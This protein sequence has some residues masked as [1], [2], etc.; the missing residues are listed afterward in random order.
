MSGVKF[1]AVLEFIYLFYTNRIWIYCY[2][3][4]CIF[5]WNGNSMTRRNWKKAIILKSKGTIHL[6]IYIYII[7]FDELDKRRYTYNKVNKNIHSIHS[8]Y[9]YTY[10]T[11]K[12]YIITTHHTYTQKEE[13]YENI[14]I[15]Y[16]IYQNVFSRYYN[17]IKPLIISPPTTK[18]Q[19]G[20]TGKMT[21]LN[22]YIDSY[23]INY[24][25][26][27]RNH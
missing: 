18:I 12:Q 16:N 8:L 6:K 7:L 17:T 21:F 19:I 5:F 4:N 1:Q 23:Q 25:I 22:N 9:I 2:Q 14:F 27:L 15:I 26:S 24:I 10:I 13:T 11:N 20:K 3:N